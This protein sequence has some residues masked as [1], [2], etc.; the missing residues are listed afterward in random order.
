M[1]LDDF[2]QQTDES[3]KFSNKSLLKCQLDHELLIDDFL[4]DPKTFRL[5][6]V[7]EVLK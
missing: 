3:I 4:V 1:L 5:I 2:L 7:K 6:D